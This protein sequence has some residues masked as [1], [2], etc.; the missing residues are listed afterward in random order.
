MNKGI[1]VKFVRLDDACE[2][3]SIERASKGKRFGIIFKS[4]F[5]GHHRV[6]GHSKQKLDIILTFSINCQ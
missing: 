2:N 6:T 3:A 4:M 1:F 5:Q